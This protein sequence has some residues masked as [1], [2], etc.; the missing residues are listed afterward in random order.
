MDDCVFSFEYSFYIYF[1]TWWNAADLLYLLN[2]VFDQ[3]SDPFSFVLPLQQ[4]HKVEK[5]KSNF[6]A[7]GNTLPILRG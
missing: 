4:R 7:W 3:A 6:Q 1:L 2:M 5:I